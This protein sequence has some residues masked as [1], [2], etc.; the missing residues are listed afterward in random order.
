MRVAIVCIASCITALVG[1]TQAPTW[2]LF[3]YADQQTIPEGAKAPYM[4]GYYQVLEQCLAKGS[5]MV[6]L[7]ET[8][9]GS[10][11]CGFK[12]QDN[13]SGE[14]ECQYFEQA[15]KR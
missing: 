7:S 10:F 8:G 1:C 6:A 12:C 14:V 5:G 15:S 11:Q 4:A 9:K 2:T 3:Y 13:G